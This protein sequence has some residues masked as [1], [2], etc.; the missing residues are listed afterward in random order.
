MELYVMGN[1]D[2]G[3]A[4]QKKDGSCVLQTDTRFGYLTW[5]SPVC[6]FQVYKFVEIF[7]R[8]EKLAYTFLE[9]L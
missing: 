9:T 5:H 3:Q 7:W 2:I 1:A 8:L 6:Y 4:T